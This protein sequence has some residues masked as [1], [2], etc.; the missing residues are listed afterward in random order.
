MAETD[1]SICPFCSMGCVFRLGR[2]AASPYLGEPGPATLDY[3]A[4]AGPNRGSLCAKGNLSLEL[5]THPRRLE[6]P[7][8]REGGSPRSVSWDEALAFVAGRMAGIREAHG[9]DAVGL[10]L[11]PQLTNEEAAA[12]VRLARAI[13]TPH[14]D[15]CEPSDHAVTRGIEMSTARPARV[16]TVEQLDAMNALLV[17]GDL[18]TLAPC[19]AKPVLNARYRERRHTLAV[20]DPTRTRT[21][22]FGRPTL[23]CEPTGEGAAL[24]MMLS[25]A[26]EG[27]GAAEAAWAQEARAV[28]SRW[29]VADLERESGLSSARASA[30]VEAL[31]AGPS[32]GVLLASEFGATAR[33]DL[34]A[35]LAA[36]LA[37]AVGARF[38]ALLEGANSCGIRATLDAEGLPGSSGHTTPELLEAAV[39]GDVK[40]L[41]VFGADPVAAFPGTI[42][43]QAMRS[44]A[45]TV[46]TAVL[47]GPATG[48]AHV[49]LPSAAF[50]EKS[51]TVRGAFGAGAAL[52]PVMAPPGRARP[53]REIL[54]A[55]AGAVPALA[56]PA[57]AASPAP[58]GLDVEART[59][60]AEIDL[61]LRSEGREGADR[62][63]GTHLLLAESS[64]TNAAEG[65]LTGQLSWARYAY[66]EPLLGLSTA[67]AAKLK[68]RDG[69]RVRV[70]SN[71]GEAELRVRVDV[72]LPEGVVTAPHR[73]P[74]V[75]GLLRWRREPAVRSLDPRPGRV[76]LERVAEGRRA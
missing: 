54:E 69:D 64:A 57:E 56:A 27:G 13:G 15:L 37:E 42:A 60:F 46:V 6:A 62:E 45:L 61:F 63:P 4:D 65:S 10:L 31:R 19:M 74:A 49:V 17:V 2:G 3:A 41:L 33:L 67:H 28:L 51:G 38:L 26:L 20:L 22:W 58:G 21:A 44:A 76:S 18:F 71:W 35:G 14:V 59:F 52:A 70:R 53:D 5:M 72:G 30:V 75:R 9:G 12:A 47:R 23:R 34:V 24:A 50:G 66:P 29:R 40:A 55:L 16:E 48:V 43:A 73:D 39:T 36:L 68:V 25:L 7:L 8:L 1:L 32:S 11:G